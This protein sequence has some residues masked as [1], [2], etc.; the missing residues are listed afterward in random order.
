MVRK[1]VSMANSL[2]RGASYHKRGHVEQEQR[3]GKDEQEMR[4]ETYGDHDC[5]G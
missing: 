3:E 5:F 1:V 4:G 2:R